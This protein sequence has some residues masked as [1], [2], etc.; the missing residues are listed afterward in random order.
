MHQE[1]ITRTTGG[2]PGEARSADADREGAAQSGTA[3]TNGEA[4]PNNR[5]LMSMWH[6][7][8]RRNLAVVVIFSVVVNLLMLTLPVYLFQIRIG[9]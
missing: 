9:S 6:A 7:A 8:V 5:D 3:P 1:L 4:K 2:L